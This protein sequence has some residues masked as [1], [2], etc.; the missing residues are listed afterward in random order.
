MN[1][2]LPKKACGNTAL[3]VLLHAEKKGMHW[4]HSSSFYRTLITFAVTYGL[5]FKNLY[6][7]LKVAIGSS[8]VLT[9]VGLYNREMQTIISLYS[10]KWQSFNESYNAATVMFNLIM[11]KLWLHSEQQC[12]LVLIG[13]TLSRNQSHQRATILLRLMLWWPQMTSQVKFLTPGWL[14]GTSTSQTTERK[15]FHL[16]CHFRAES[17]RCLVFFCFLC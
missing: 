11:L 2:T 10:K 4:M 17:N 8:S 12:E 1:G 6:N 7:C 15:K 3:L 14:S 9:H 5:F 16:H 13:E